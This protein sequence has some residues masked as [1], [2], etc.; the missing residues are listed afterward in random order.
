MSD[1]S[2]PFRP[3]G[4][5][6]LDR[7]LAG[8]GAQ[9]TR[10]RRR[11][12]LIALEQALFVTAGA[13]VLSLTLLVLLAFVLSPLGYACVTWLTLAAVVVTGVTR[14]RRLRRSWVPGA[15]AAVMI[16]HRAGLEDRL[17]TL[18]TADAAAR[19]SRLWNFLLRENLRLLPRWEPRRVAPRLLP[20]SVWFFLC[21]LLLAALVAYRI[22][23][24]DG[25]TAAP[26][27]RLPERSKDAPADGSG[28]SE[29]A[30]NAQGSALARLWRD[31]PERMRQAIVGQSSARMFAGSIPR[32][33]APVHD[34]RNAP[35][36][37][38]SRISN[39]GPVRSEAATEQ[40][41]RL[42]ERSSAGPPGRDAE[43]RPA[44]RGPTD[45]A[46]APARGDRPKT[47]PN[48]L[49]GDAPKS[50]AKGSSAAATGGGAGAGMGGDEKGLLGDRH[51]AE[52][53]RGSF[54]FDLDALRGGKSGPAGEGE[55][56]ARPPAALGPEQRLDDAVRRAQV[57]PEYEKIVQRLFSRGVEDGDPLL[58][59]ER[60]E[61][62][63]A[64]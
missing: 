28:E 41:R 34:E 4:G 8:V 18:T 38:G 55:P 64:R 53:A 42:A 7:V 43:R 48:A 24:A 46:A 6:P 12:N 27:A 26:A 37:V 5:G 47:L 29:A 61:D 9:T 15:A 1:A 39:S 54:T 58:A 49:R 51:A 35:A 16:D 52:E 44:D 21:S 13:V 57:P 14:L 22:P 20:R 30:Q 19:A 2:L 31:L 23:R 11:L 10:V 63:G 33:T 17:A 56:S 60:D 32:K 62:R 59:R 36:I 50:L 3:R 45:P 40:A 25:R